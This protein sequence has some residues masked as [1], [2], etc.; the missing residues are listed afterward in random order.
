[1]K[2]HIKNQSGFSL[3]ELLVAM[4]IMGLVFGGICELF[5][6]S[7]RLNNN[8]NKETVTQM[9]LRQ[10]L[11]KISQELR[12]A[13]NITC[14]GSQIYFD[15][16]SGEKIYY[17]LDKNQIYRKIGESGTSQSIT[18]KDVKIIVFMPTQPVAEDLNYVQLEAAASFV[19]FGSSTEK[20]ERF[21]TTI[22]S[23]VRS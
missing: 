22:H 11:A 20:T 7:L 19:I 6:I 4:A 17:F 8:T 2:R 14:S 23:L 5:A 9:E 10:T 13:K 21:V 16:N 15:N 12:Y 1:M 18:S 3:V